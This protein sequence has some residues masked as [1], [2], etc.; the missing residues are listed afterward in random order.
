MIDITQVPFNKLLGISLAS[1]NDYLLQ[2]DAK[3]EYTNHLGTVHAAAL[4]ALAEGSGA[5]LLLKAFPEELIEN[6]IPVLR[7][8]EVSYKKPAKGVVKSKAFL[9]DNNFENILLELQTKKRVLLTTLVE[10]F[11]E[12]TVKVFAAN[13]EWFVVLK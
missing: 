3:T 5:Q 2:L 9:I 6:V 8:V 7:K 10:L 12:Q 13:F 4:F 1:N 11:D